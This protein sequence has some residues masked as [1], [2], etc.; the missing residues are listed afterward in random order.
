VNASAGGQHPQPDPPSR[1]LWQ[2]S[3]APPPP[4]PSIPSRVDAV[5][6]GAGLTGLSAARALRQRGLSVLVLEAR[7]AGAGASGSNGGQVLT[8][9]NLG[10][11]ALAG[12]FGL[13]RARALWRDSVRAVDTVD[14]LIGELGIACDWHRGGHLEAAVDAADW[15]RLAREGEQLE[16]LVGYTTHLWDKEQAEAALGSAYYQGGLFDPRCGSLN[17]YR[18]T[19]GLAEAARSEGVTMAEG[20]PFRGFSTRPRFLIRHGQG[21]T[22][23]QCLILA[24]NAYLPRWLR[25]LR[26]FIL[27]ITA[28]VV[29]TEVLPPPWQA[30]ILPRRPTVS[31]SKTPM[32]YFQKTGAGHLVFGGGGGRRHPPPEAYRRLIGWMHEVFP[33]LAGVAVPFAW[34]GPI[35]LSRD[36]LP[37]LGRTAAGYYSVGGYSGHGVA[38]AVW[39]G[40][41]VGEWAAAEAAVA[42]PWAALAVPP[43]AVRWRRYRGAGSL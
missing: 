35:A 36:G 39:L 14:R 27:P 4:P 40:Q 31:D 32:F 42:E 30:V 17:P 1:N 38:L 29:A 25:P 3:V 21:T 9:F 10:I 6:V 5:V 22:R 12:R 19:Q 8:G 37:H 41:L 26:L 43:P 24:G 11:D 2:Q 16:R 33:M 7:R 15:Q 20:V 13:E 23:C 28:R 18:F 34:S